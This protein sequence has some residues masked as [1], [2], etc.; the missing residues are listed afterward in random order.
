MVNLIVVSKKQNN[1]R[2]WSDALGGLYPVFCFTSIEELLSK[3]DESDTLALLVVDAMLVKEMNQVSG[4]C[5]KFCKIIVFGENLSSSEKIQFIYEGACGYSDILIDEKMIV[6]AVES[7]INNEIW[8]ERRLIPEMLKGSIVKRNQ[9]VDEEILNK[10]VL[11]TLPCLTLRETTVVELVYRGQDNDEIADK[12]GISVRTVKAH[13]SAVY[14][15]FETPNRFQ[16]VILLKNLH[17]KFLSTE[18]EGAFQFQ[19]ASRAYVESLG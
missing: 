4:L 13:L 9:H 10:A 11:D 15:K 2:R 3:R 18:N 19:Q 17:V 12:L 14:H 8:L 16:L 6:R 5:G 7:V 1:I